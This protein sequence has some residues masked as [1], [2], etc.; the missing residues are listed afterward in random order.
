[1]SVRGIGIITG[2]IAGTRSGTGETGR[3]VWSRQNINAWDIQREDALL[4]GQYDDRQCV[5]A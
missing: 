2:A 1:V 5:S 3:D 4:P